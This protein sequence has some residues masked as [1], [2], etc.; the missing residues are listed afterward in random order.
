[1]NAPHFFAS[2]G[3]ISGVGLA[4]AKMIGLVFIF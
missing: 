1:M 3:E 4:R 2:S